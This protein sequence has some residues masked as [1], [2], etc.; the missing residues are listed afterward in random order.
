MCWVCFAGFLGCTKLNSD[1]SVQL[2]K[3]VGLSRFQQ[4]VLSDKMWV[5]PPPPE[6]NI[7]SDT[8]LLGV[9]FPLQQERWLLRLWIPLPRLG[10]GCSNVYGS[11]CPSNNL[12]VWTFLQIWVDWDGNASWLPP[13][14]TCLGWTKCV[15]KKIPLVIHCLPPGRQPHEGKYWKRDGA[16][17]GTKC[18]CWIQVCGDWEDFGFTWAGCDQSGSKAGAVSKVWCR[19]QLL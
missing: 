5:P 18:T 16:H 8:L 9:F 14:D 19:R 4:N 6:C 1:F 3:K 10:C 2:K 11:A 17:P 13:G 7:N 15:L 12:Q